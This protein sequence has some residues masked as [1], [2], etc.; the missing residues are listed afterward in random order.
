MNKAIHLRE[1]AEENTWIVTFADL[2]TLLLVFF[3]LLFSISTIKEESFKETIDSVKSAL[4]GTGQG[5]RAG[6]GA[7]TK[8]DKDSTKVETGTVPTD[9]TDPSVETGDKQQAPTEEIQPIIATPFVITPPKPS[10]DREA[11]LKKQD[12]AR[13]SKAISKLMKSAAGENDSKIS[14]P[15]DGKIIINVRGDLFFN[16]GSAQF[17]REAMPIMDGIGNILR[18]NNVFKLAIGGHTDNQPIS[19]NRYPSNWE[20]SAIR[21]TTV[22]RYFVRGGMSPD[23]LTAT[24]YGES[25]PLDSNDTELQRIENR[26]IEF[27]LERKSL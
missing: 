27:V 1:E 26:R 8:V 22:L 18:K 9:S 3:I 14:P 6:A 23:R 13:V 11:H 10:I 4:K 2:V 12:M 5:S 19:T 16:K 15:K 24:G 25:I 20:L 21:A 7:G 17:K